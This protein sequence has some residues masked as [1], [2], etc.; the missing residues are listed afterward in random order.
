VLIAFGGL[1][2]LVAHLRRGSV[3]VATGDRV[4]EGQQLGVIGNSGNTLA[5]HLH[6]QVM[7]GAD[8]AAAR[9]VP[10]RVR[11]LEHRV[12]DR[13]IVVRGQRLPGRLARVRMNLPIEVAPPTAGE[14]PAPA[15]LFWR[16]GERAN[17]L[18]PSVISIGH[19]DSR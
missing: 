12:G 14:C 17:D 5:P 6:F 18:A 19:S 10:F 3:T 8:F 9:V 13:W 2:A 15:T 4:T 16:P 1:V 11:V 7:D